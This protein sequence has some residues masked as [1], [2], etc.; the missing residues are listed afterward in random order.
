MRDPHVKS[1]TFQLKTDGSVI[2]KDASPLT[3]TTSEFAGRLDGN[4]LVISMVEHYPS[5]EDARLAVEPYLCSWETN[6]LLDGNRLKFVFV[7][8]DVIDRNPPALGEHRIIEARAHSSSTATVSAT[9]V[10]IKSSYPPPPTIFNRSPL[11]VAMVDR[12]DQYLKGGESL[13]TVAYYC[14]TA[15]ERSAA[16]GEEGSARKKTAAKYRIDLDVLKQVGTLSSERGS[17]LE[18]RKFGRPL[19]SDAERQWLEAAIRRLIRQIAAVDGGDEKAYLSMGD[20]PP[21]TP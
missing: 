6:T 17:A 13:F 1:L 5:E 11:V 20:L 10:I 18:A 12:L 14:V 4:E 2:F 21:L 7:S 3:F 9:A 19:P 16:P 8:S 15:I